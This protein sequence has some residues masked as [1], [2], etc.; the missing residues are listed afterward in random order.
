M[1][2][3]LGYEPDADRNRAAHR[4]ADAVGE[5]SGTEHGYGAPVPGLGNVLVPVDPE[6]PGLEAAIERLTALA[7]QVEADARG[8]NAHRD[9][10]RDQP[11]VELPT[12][13][14]GAHG[15]DLEAVAEATGLHAADVVELHASVEYRVLFLGF[16]PGFAY[17]GD[18]PVSLA[19][20]RLAT[21]RARVPG[22]SVGIAGRTTAVYPFATPGGWQL[23]GRTEVAIWD[24]EW[25][26]PALLTPGMRVRFVPTADPG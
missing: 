2:V 26:R 24:L 11:L 13:Y 17:L 16:A 14:G 12:R 19:V 3:D 9:D 25:S 18:L 6:R 8:P 1:L 21:P 15:P 22:G 5:L 10:D 4:L 20:P 23:I 7:A